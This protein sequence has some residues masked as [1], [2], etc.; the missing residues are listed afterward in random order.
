ME[1]SSTIE[2]FDQFREHL[3]GVSPEGRYFFRGEPR[4]FYRLIPKIGR[5]PRPAK[6]NVDY[7]ETERSVFDKFKARARPFLQY[8]PQN[9]W[10]WLTLAQHHGLPTRLLDWTTNPLIALYFAVEADA[11]MRCA[12]LHNPDYDGSRAFYW[13]VRKFGVDFVDL[14]AQPDPFT[15]EDVT[16]IY[17]AFVTTRLPS[18]SGLF[19]IQPDP[20]KPLN[21]QANVRKYR[22]AAKARDAIRSE[23]RLLGVHQAS[24]FPDLDG[25]CGQ[26]QSALAGYH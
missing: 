4:D 22:I 10:E 18:Q 17:P 7:T 2:S 21:E 24:V 6:F 11:D 5:Y 12:Q 8:L 3:T 23:L 26:L 20:Y 14:K 1:C 13:L 15:L 19:T 16:A 9:D 25:L